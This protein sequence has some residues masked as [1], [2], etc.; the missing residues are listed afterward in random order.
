MNSKNRLTTILLFACVKRQMSHFIVKVLLF[1]ALVATIVRAAEEAVSEKETAPV[2]NVQPA[3]VATKRKPRSILQACRKE[4]PTLCKDRKDSM[5]CLTSKA[6]EVSDKVCKEWLDARA[7]CN[8]FLKDNKK[9]AAKEN[10]R[11]CLRNIAKEELPSDCAES[12]YYKSVKLFGAF[13]RRASRPPQ[14]K[15]V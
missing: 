2:E 13:R 11:V 3:E 15:S 1:I 10:A 8:K 9:C 4:L 14:S 7:G 12:D 5:R 6:P